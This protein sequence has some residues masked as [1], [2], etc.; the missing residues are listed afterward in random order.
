MLNLIKIS[1]NANLILHLCYLGPINH[2]WCLCH[3]VSLFWF[4]FYI[5]DYGSEDENPLM[6][7][8]FPPYDSIENE[9]EPTL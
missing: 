2:F 1:F 7:A 8:H 6:L 3:V 4:P 5:M 9:R